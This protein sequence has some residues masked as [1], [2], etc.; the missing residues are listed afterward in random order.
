[1]RDVATPDPILSPDDAVR[2]LGNRVSKQTLARWRVEGRPPN[3]LR[4]SAR[5]GYRQSALDHFLR[6]CE[7]RSTSDRGPTPESEA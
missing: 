6:E 3:W 2:Y 4:I 1:M 7:R 5:V